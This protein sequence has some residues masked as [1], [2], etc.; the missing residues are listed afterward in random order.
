MTMRTAVIYLNYFPPAPRAAPGVYIGPAIDTLGYERLRY[1]FLV[2][3]VLGG[4]VTPSVGL[5]E[6]DTPDPGEARVFIDPESLAV[7]A[8][9]PDPLA[10][11]ECRLGREAGRKRFLRGRIDLVG[12]GLLCCSMAIELVKPE[13]G[14][15]P[16]G[17][18]QE[19]RDEL[20][21]R[22]FAGRSIGL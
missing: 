15:G 14:Q 9:K 2:G 12:E 13:P 19:L 1:T 8:P 6:A 18:G 20:S 4:L 16:D 3:Q 5:V 7:V 22:R 17:G 21:F 11:F 10:C